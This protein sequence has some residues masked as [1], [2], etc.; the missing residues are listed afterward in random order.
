VS[1]ASRNDIAKLLQVFWEVFASNI[2]HCEVE[3]RELQEVSS[4]STS[5]NQ[6]S[7][8][9]VWGGDAGH[10]IAIQELGKLAMVSNTLDKGNHILFKRFVNKQL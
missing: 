9:R 6:P 10:W 5:S 2:T 8:Q 4:S 7:N 1:S 3:T